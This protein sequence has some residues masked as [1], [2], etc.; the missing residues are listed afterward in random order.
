MAATSVIGLHARV[1]AEASQFV[2]ELNRADNAQRRTMSSMKESVGKSMKYIEKQFSITKLTKGM[3]H[4][5]GLSTG[6]G[7]IGGAIETFSDKLNESKEH[8]K[9]MSEWVSKMRD[10]LR[11]LSEKRYASFM[12][13]IAPEDK[14][15]IAIPRAEQHTAEIRRQLEEAKKEYA[16]ASEDIG[17]AGKGITLNT[18][19]VFNPFTSRMVDAIAGDVTADADTSLERQTKAGEQIQRLQDELNK[20]LKDE[21]GIRKDITEMQK[22]EEDNERKITDE[23]E[24]FVQKQAEMDL[25]F[26]KGYLNRIQ[27]NADIHIDDMTKRGL[28]SGA[29]YDLVQ[30]STNEILKKIS[31]QIK[32]YAHKNQNEQAPVYAD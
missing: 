19:K 17:K 4:G 21:K 2:N 3:I 12:S 1:T 30:K 27:R 24:Q 16:A 31:D 23:C 15:R 22:K 5:F 6:A 9:E 14:A 10:D 20:A 29:R 28:G 11:E 7:L 26:G 32:E 13:G 18:T 8:A 25:K